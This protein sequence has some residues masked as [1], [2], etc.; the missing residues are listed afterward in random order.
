MT[1]SDWHFCITLLSRVFFFFFLSQMRLL[2]CTYFLTVEFHYLVHLRLLFTRVLFFL[3]YF[4]AQSRCHKGDN[5]IKYFTRYVKEKWHDIASLSHNFLSK[6]FFLTKFSIDWTV[7]LL[8]PTFFSKWDFSSKRV[9][10]RQNSIIFVHSRF[11]VTKVDF[12]S[13]C[14]F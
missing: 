7:F 10:W 2:K 14:V 3:L 5:F 13:F 9:F 6:F 11:L 1:E 12:F 8:R 4:L